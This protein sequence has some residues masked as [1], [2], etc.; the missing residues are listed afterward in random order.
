MISIIVPVYNV[1]D[2]IE[3]C[4]ASLLNQTKSEFEIILVDD[5][6]TDGSG[7]I[8]DK[9][10]KTDSRIQVIHQQNRGLSGARNQGLKAAMGEWITYIDSDDWVDARYLEVLY[11]NAVQ[12]QAEIS[13]CSF[14][15]VWE[16]ENQRKKKQLREEKPYMLTGKEAAKEIV[17]NSRRPM[18]TAW[19]KLYHKNLKGLL[20][21]P[22]GRIHEDEFVTYRVMYAADTVVVSLMPLYKYLQRE[23]SIMNAGYSEK[24]LD[25]LEALKEAVIFFTQAGDKEMAAAAVKRYL[26][27]I[28]IAWYRVKKYMPK[29]KD[30]QKRLRQEWKDTYQG[31]RKAALEASNTTDK[32]ALLVFGTF[33]S[34]YGI[35]AGIYIRI[36]PEA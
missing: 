21:Y 30:L 19:G 2:Y 12:H 22:E 31:K 16:K 13:V 29:R 25:K 28:Q 11:Q 20:E 7:A 3:R 36:F 18:I 8:C 34:L 23:G 1:K 6:S 27:N 10:Q 5:G 35:I 14:E 24:R 4:V 15:P 17:K 9:L 26:L 32:I 33:P